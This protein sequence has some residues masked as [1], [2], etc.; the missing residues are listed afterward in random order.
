VTARAFLFAAVAAAV[1]ALGA[2]SVSSAAP[3]PTHWCGGTDEAATDRLPDA[4][5]SYQLHV[6]YAI[7]S[8]GA[9]RFAERAF[10]IARDLALVDTWWRGQDPT[11]TLRWDLSAFAGCDSI[12]GGVDISFLRL[13]LPGSAYSSLDDAAY[14]ALKSGVFAA[15]SD[16]YKKYA[17]YYDGPIDPTLGVCGVSSVG[18]IDRGASAAF[19]FLNGDPNGLCG[20]VGNGDYMAQ[21][22]AHE[23]IHNLGAVSPEA[24]HVCHGAHVCDVVSDVMQPQGTSNNLFDYVLDAG[25]DD[26]YGHSGS[27]WDVQDSLWLSHLDAPQFTLTVATSGAGQGS[28]A[29]DLPGIACPPACSIAWDSGTVVTLT[30]TTTGDRTRFAGWTGDCSGTDVCQATI[31]SAKT[32]AAQFVL[33]SS[34]AVSIVKKGGSGFV[35]SI[36]SGID[37]PEGAC[38]SLYDTGSKIALTAVPD[39]RSRIVSWSVP[40]CGAAATCSVTANADRSVSVTFGPSS[41][42][43]SASVN[44]QGHVTST[45]AGIACPGKCAAS[46]PFAASVRLSARPAKGWRFAG[47]SGACHGSASCAVKVRAAGVVHA[48]FRRV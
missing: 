9:D 27:W 37:C 3:A 28:V 1:I 48:V 17:V 46:F 47:W 13:P 38:D 19:V 45:P 15:F 36:P 2:P 22:L 31:S 6:I 29:S 25:R 44:G 32:V 11:R 21:V 8:D 10:P 20:S 35:K 12:F 5:A 24:P 33:E 4:V 34:L 39:R 26:Y 18:P 16:V 40:S 7:P 30:P 41:Y 14:A 23:V 42:R 43:L